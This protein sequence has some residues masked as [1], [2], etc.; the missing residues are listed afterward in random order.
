MG[1]LVEEVIAQGKELEQ[2]RLTQSYTMDILTRVQGAFGD[3]PQR[4]F[5]QTDDRGSPSRGTEY[6]HT[7]CSFSDE[8]SCNHF[9]I[10]HTQGS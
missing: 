7:D 10:S 2:L 8:C 6:H 4:Q 1:V 3:F 9:I 5:G